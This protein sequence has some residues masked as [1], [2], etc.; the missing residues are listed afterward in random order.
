MK[1]VSPW[2]RIKVKIAPMSPINTPG[3]SPRSS[4]LANI[5]DMAKPTAAQTISNSIFIV[6]KRTVD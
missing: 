4:C 3:M 5:K 1:L 6:P 2:A